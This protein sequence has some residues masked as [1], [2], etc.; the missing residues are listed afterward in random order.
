LG[1]LKMTT[2]REAAEIG[3]DYINHALVV[4]DQA[5]GDHPSMEKERDSI[6][7]DKESVRQAL[8]EPDTGIDRGAW[9]DV[10]DATKWV[11]ELRGDEPEANARLIAAAPDLLESCEA[12]L[13]LPK[14][15]DW[16]NALRNVVTQARAAVAKAKGETE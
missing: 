6:V 15:D 3:L 14:S 2:L 1:E 10:P 13:D 11:D 5:Y 7:A 12:L 4:H 8:A 9:S 16:L